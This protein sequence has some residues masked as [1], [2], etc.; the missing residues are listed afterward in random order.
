LD[1][2]EILRKAAEKVQHNRNQAGPSTAATA[3]A[4]DDY[5]DSD[6]ELSPIIPRVLR[7]HTSSV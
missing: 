2:A 1:A 3:P 5:V 4:E 7:S 6:E